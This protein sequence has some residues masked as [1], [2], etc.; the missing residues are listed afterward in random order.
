MGK[1]VIV[2]D[3]DRC[4][5]CKSCEFACA[6][7]H[8]ASKDMYVMVQTGE[9]PGNRISVE[10]FGRKAIPVNCNH[11]EEPACIMAC[12]TGAVHR[13]EERGPVLVNPEYCIGC[14]MCVQSCPF[15][16]ITVRADGKGVVKCDLCVER[17]A[18]GQ[19]PACVSSCPTKALLFIEEE[20]SNRAKRKRVA[21]QLVIALEDAPPRG[22]SR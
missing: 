6:V 5:G 18:A 12:P 11:C 21:R 10:S 20:E 15:G 16:V 14:H 1:K 4:M 3:I 9:K 2:V 17:L 13:K 7:A 19:Q 8:S 22:A